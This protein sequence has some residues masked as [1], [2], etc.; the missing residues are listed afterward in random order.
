MTTDERIAELEAEVKRLKHQLTCDS[1]CGGS[2]YDCICLDSDA[3]MHRT[4]VGQRMGMR[5]LLRRREADLRTEIAELTA[6][7]AR[8]ADEL[9]GVRE[10]LALSQSAAEVEAHEV[11]DLNAKITVLRKVMERLLVEHTQWRPDCGILPTTK[12]SHGP[13]CTC[14]TCGWHHDDCV[15]EHNE[16]ET[17]LKSALKEQP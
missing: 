2:F 10:E 5:R 7:N 9:A 12:P 17:I 6:A 14:G 3:D 15:C 13:C 4:V 8:L 11:D 1:C 16:I